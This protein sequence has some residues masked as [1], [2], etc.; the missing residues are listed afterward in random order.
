MNPRRTQLL[1]SAIALAER[2]NE[3]TQLSRLQS[4]SN[5][6]LAGRFIRRAFLQQKASLRMLK[7]A[8]I[9]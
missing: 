5:M 9:N 3:N 6:D 4:V 7:W 8:G 2:S 1:R